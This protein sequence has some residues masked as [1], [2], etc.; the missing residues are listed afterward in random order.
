MQLIL[1]GDDAG[2]SLAANRGILTACRAR[3]LPNASVMAVGPALDA[4]AGPLR[5]MGN[6][7]CVGLHVT[8]NC[9]W[10]DNRWGP[11][12]PAADVGSLVMPDG[13]FTRSPAALHERDADRAQIRAEIEAQLATLRRAGL[14]VSYVDE[15]MG[16]GW[17]PG[18]RDL[19]CELADREGL[20]VAARFAHLSLKDVAG[21]GQLDRIAAALDKIEPGL[22]ATDARVFITHPEAPSPSDPPDRRDP[23]EF[24]ARQADLALLLDPALD[25]LLSQRD[26]SAVTYVQANANPST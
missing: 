15:H 7:V 16:V 1:R 13:T 19:I 22:S 25:V 5:E 4:L 20:I 17:L 11:I 23:S 6:S 8:L 14:T 9:E 24:R 12:L 21:D 2:A 18:V 3:R 26:V 10:S